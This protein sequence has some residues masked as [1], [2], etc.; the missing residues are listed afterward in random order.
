[1]VVI[2]EIVLHLRPGITLAPS[3]DSPG[4]NIARFDLGAGPSLVAGGTLGEMKREGWVRVLFACARVCSC[5]CARG[6]QSPAFS[7]RPVV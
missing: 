6:C 3:T 1:M 7:W 4:L 5:A 2:I